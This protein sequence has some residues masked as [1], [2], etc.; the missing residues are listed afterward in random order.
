M[1]SLFLLEPISIG[2]LVLNMQKNSH[3]H[4]KEGSSVKP[5]ANLLEKSIRELEKMVA[6]CE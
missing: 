6:E 5:K 3:L 2:D 4:K 1:G